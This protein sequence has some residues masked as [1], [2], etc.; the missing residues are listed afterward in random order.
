MGSEYEPTERH[1]E[2]ARLF[3]AGGRDTK[4]KWEASARKAGFERVPNK[5][6]GVME[7]AFHKVRDSGRLVDEETVELANRLSLEDGWEGAAVQARKMLFNIGAGFEEATAGQVT[8]LKEIIAR[9][10]GKV[11][12]VASSERPMGVLILPALVADDGEPWMG[13]DP[14]EGDEIFELHKEHVAQ[15]ISS[16][17]REELGV[18]EPDV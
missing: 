4:G 8:A 11:G 12:Q 10:E 9:A 16:R 13:E 5:A 2:A 6:S 18:G 17:R 7:K 15:A 1:L 3:L 14:E